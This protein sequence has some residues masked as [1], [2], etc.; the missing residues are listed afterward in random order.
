MCVLGVWGKKVGDTNNVG[1]RFLRTNDI[2]G[3][4]KYQVRVIGYKVYGADAARS[5]LRI[6]DVDS[7]GI[8]VAMIVADSTTHGKVIISFC[9]KVVHRRG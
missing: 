9:I 7:D 8:I 1:P 4:S 3:T 2:P 6:Q 5:M